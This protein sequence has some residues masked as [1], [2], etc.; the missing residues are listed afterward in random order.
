M[1]ELHATIFE[2]KKTEIDALENDTVAA[3]YSFLQA[4]NARCEKI[5]KEMEKHKNK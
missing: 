3:Y 4:N 2:G 5:R 1:G